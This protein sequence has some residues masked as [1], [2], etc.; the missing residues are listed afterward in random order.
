[1]EIYNTL[2]TKRGCLIYDL[3]DCQEADYLFCG[4]KNAAPFLYNPTFDR[5]VR[6]LVILV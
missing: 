2:D 5:V 6:T 4:S 3:V 1:M